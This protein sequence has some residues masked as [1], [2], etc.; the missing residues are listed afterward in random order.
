MWFAASIG[1]HRGMHEILQMTGNIL[2][3][4]VTVD[5]TAHREKK[6]LS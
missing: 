3:W 6:A 1:P 2:R 4:L 5:T